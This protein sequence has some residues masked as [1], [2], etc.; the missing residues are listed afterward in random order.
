MDSFAHD[1]L[2]VSV[3]CVLSGEAT[4]VPVGKTLITPGGLVDSVGL[5]NIITKI[6]GEPI[7]VILVERNTRPGACEPVTGVVPNGTVSYGG[8]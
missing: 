4:N 3:S 5:N 1:D 8:P 2:K 7:K 6:D